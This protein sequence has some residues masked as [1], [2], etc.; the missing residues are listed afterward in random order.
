MKKLSSVLQTLLPRSAKSHWSRLKNNIYTPNQDK[1]CIF[2]QDGELE[3]KY[4][5]KA[6]K[7]IVKEVLHRMLDP[8][9]KELT[10]PHSEVDEQAFDYFIKQ[11]MRNN[12]NRIS[13]LMIKFSRK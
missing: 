13:F 12:A 2:L 4:T 10:Y 6:G 11:D 8:V 3:V 1:E 7:K 5:K 9:E